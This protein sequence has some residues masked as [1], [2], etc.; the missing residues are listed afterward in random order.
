MNISPIRPGDLVR[1]DVRGE[2]FVAEVTGKAEG[3]LTL[4]PVARSFLPAY[5]VKSRQVIEHWRRSRRSR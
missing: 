4:E 3:V 2:K 1:C 5:R